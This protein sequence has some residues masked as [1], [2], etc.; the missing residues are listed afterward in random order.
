M[1]DKDHFKGRSALEHL[2]EARKKARRETDATHGLE[3]PGHLIAGADSA[4]VTAVIALLFWIVFEGCNFSFA[5][6]ATMMS[7]AFVGWLIWK[8]C[9]SAIY[10]WSRLEKLHRVIDEERKEIETNREQE[11]EELTE[12]YKAKGFTGK[13]LEDVIDVL[14]ADDNRLLNVM[15][16]EELGLSLESYE[17]PLKQALGAGIGTL[18]ASIFIM[19]GT[20][21]F[22]TIGII[23][24]TIIVTALSSFT[25]ATIE[26][27]NRLPIIVW[28][29]SSLAV[30]ILVTY[31]ITN[32]V[33]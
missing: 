1:S 15:L 3:A 21:A 6:R 20:L 30:A 12:M 2:K 24:A 9:R 17:H 32:M 11:K 27:N 19:I 7:L 23:C 16:E 28:D 5:Q 4:K 29:I 25:I 31:F 8:V 33:R 22:G 13:L 26:R 14:M 18:S 10:G